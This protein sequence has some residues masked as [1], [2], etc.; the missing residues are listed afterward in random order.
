LFK[1]YSKNPAVTFDDAARRQ[2]QAAQ[3][4][5]LAPE[6]AAAQQWVRA[7]TRTSPLPDELPRPLVASGR[8]LL[9]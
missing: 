1:T 7:Q 4:A 5:A 6:I 9:A 2:R 3:A 8:S